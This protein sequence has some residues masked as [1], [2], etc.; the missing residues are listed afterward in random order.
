MDLKATEARLQL[1]GAHCL[2]WETG[3]RGQIFSVGHRPSVME[4]LEVLRRVGRGEVR[5]GV[6]PLGPYRWG[7]GMR[8]WG[9]E[10]MVSC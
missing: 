4:L 9:R 7:S 1:W 2:G 10:W 3:R 5:A 6:A 8:V